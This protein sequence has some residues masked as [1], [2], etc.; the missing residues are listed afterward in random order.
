MTR[1]LY[2]NAY[3]PLENLDVSLIEVEKAKD[4]SFAITRQTKNDLEAEE[5]KLTELKETDTLALIAKDREFNSKIAS[6]E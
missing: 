6:L 5:K 4:E 3:Y 2:Y 1:Q